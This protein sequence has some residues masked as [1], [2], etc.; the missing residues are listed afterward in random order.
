[1]TSGDRIPWHRVPERG[2]KPRSG[3]RGLYA[4]IKIAGSLSLAVSLPT[5]LVAFAGS[6]GT[7]ALPCWGRISLSSSP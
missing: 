3:G 1:M 5:M 7:K 4:D 6:A 2:D